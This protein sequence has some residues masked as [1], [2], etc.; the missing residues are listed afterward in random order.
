MGFEDF[1]LASGKLSAIVNAAISAQN[2]QK[3]PKAETLKYHK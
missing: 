3:L 1:S 2:C